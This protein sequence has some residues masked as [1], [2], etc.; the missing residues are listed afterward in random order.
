MDYHIRLTKPYSILEVF[1]RNLQCDQLI[2]YQHN[3]GKRPH[4]HC[5]AKNVPIQV[6]TLK[7]R[8]TKLCGTWAKEDWAFTTKYKAG[9]LMLPINDGLI[10]YMSKGHYEPSLVV[11][12]DEQ[13][14][15]ELTALWVERERKKPK[16]PTY[17]TIIEQVIAMAV[18]P[19]TGAEL[20]H[21]IVDV[22][23][24]HKVV[25]GRY[26]VRDI[27]DTILRRTYKYTF[28]NQMT[29]MLDFPKKKIF[30]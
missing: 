4:V 12:F 17:D 1:F 20:L 3:D 7:A 27:Y 28:I 29:D 16:K 19:I 8:L 10:T 25:C 2:V 23:N 5:L 14:V 26:K 11:G 18:G 6:T 30:T 24:K 22:L 21:N 9:D 13:K 15:A